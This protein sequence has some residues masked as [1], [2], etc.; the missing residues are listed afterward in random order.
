MRGILA[1]VAVL[2]ASVVSVGCGSEEETNPQVSSA[3]A[4]DLENKL[5]E[6]QERVDRED[7]SAADEALSSLTSAVPE[8]DANQDFKDDFTT[9]LSDLGAQISEQCTTTAA[10][11]ETSTETEEEPSTE[12]TTTTPSTET[13]STE[14]VPDEE[15]E[16]EDEGD[17]EEPEN[18]EDLL[19][20]PPVEP[21]VTPGNSGGVSPS[22]GSF[23]PERQGTPPKKDKKPK[24]D[25]P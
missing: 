25:K 4:T 11:E 20:D 16:T 12:S 10:A 17:E 24:K 8:I 23:E 15:E 22:D 18:P 21:P 19:P 7:C 2:G 6:I 5:D 3:A 9:L 13:S 14:T 1:C